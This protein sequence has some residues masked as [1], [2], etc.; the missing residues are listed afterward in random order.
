MKVGI[1]S[2]E[3]ELNSKTLRGITTTTRYLQMNLTNVGIESELIIYSK[4]ACKYDSDSF[5]IKY[6]PHTLEDLENLHSE[7]DFII[8]FTPGLSWEKFD[9]KDPDRYTDVINAL[10][11]P[12]TFI[13]HSEEYKA[14]QPYRVNFLSH[15]LCKFVIFIAEDLAEIYKE[16]LKICPYYTVAHVLPPV[17]P[18][19]EI[20]SNKKSNSIC[21]TSVWT[22]FKRN[23][24]YFELVP[25]FEEL[26]IKAYSA[27]A[28]AS[29]Y[30]VNDI[31]DY[32]I[33]DIEFI[34][35]DTKSADDHSMS[36]Y[37]DYMIMYAR[38]KKDSPY[39]NMEIPYIDGAI[40]H[41]KSGYHWTDYGFYY[42]EEIHSIL[43][44]KKFHWCMS[45]YK[46]DS[47]KYGNRLEV[48]T[49]EAFNEGCIPVICK[50]YAPLDL[51]DGVDCFI[52]SKYDYQNRVDELKDISESRRQE[53]LKNFYEKYKSTMDKW[54]TNLSKLIEMCS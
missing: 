32:L 41:T 38:M 29:N 6:N 33:D 21:I 15:P 8:Y 12:F 3:K 10:D 45:C 54:Y 31:V 11:L 27:G 35:D 4:K 49:A 43:E 19:E 7:F 28:P 42:P 25:K 37:K 52:F 48:V 18:I 2:F 20:L 17:K 30:Y 40:I 34:T 23:L 46:R 24:E 14:H 39:A 13:Y 22:N 44:D 53:M 1:L 26:G 47:Y 36:K 50:E 51:E 16:D 9:K 5:N